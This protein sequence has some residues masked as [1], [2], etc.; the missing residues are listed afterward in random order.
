MSNRHTHS[1]LNA[2]KKLPVVVA[3]VAAATCPL[4][5]GFVNTGAQTKTATSPP[6][7]FEVASVRPNLNPPTERDG[8]VR[9]GPDGLA[10]R[11]AT[12]K[13]LVMWAYG[14]KEFQ[15]AGGPDWLGSQRY[16]I[17]A[18]AGT[19][20]NEDQLMQMLQALLA[21]RFKLE[22]H[23]E[24]RVLAVTALVIGKSGPKL[25]E[26]PPGDRLHG[27]IRFEMS[28]KAMRLTGEKAPMPELASW[29]TSILGDAARPVLDKT[30]LTGAY[31]FVLEWIPDEDFPATAV[32]A[33]LPE[34]LGLKLDAA[35]A[36]FEVVVINH[37][38]KVPTAN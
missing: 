32:A 17:Q 8:F 37:A 3:A 9:P 38:E 11:S 16:D 4:I 34:Q 1:A 5:F 31:D 21:E 2:S 33:A 25:H 13:S 28:G 14:L 18:K 36:P 19:P 24:T 10:A 20:V 27:Q 29:L 6:P 12:L 23:R 35:R 7:K 22:V 26:V 15:I 30:G